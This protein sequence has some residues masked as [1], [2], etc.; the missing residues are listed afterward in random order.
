[1]QTLPS[2]PKLRRG[3]SK[4]TFLTPGMPT[5]CSFYRRKY[6]RAGPYEKH[7]RTAH[8]DLSD[9]L[10]CYK[11]RLPPGDHV[12]M[13]SHL[14]SHDEQAYKKEQADSD[15]ESDLDHYSHEPNALDEVAS[16]ADVVE[17]NIITISLASHEPTCYP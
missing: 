2:Y 14:L 6:T 4:P 15:Y 1:M 17:P 7:L 8:A 5:N 11:Q 9:I 13:E 3:F 12:H 16:E 10:A